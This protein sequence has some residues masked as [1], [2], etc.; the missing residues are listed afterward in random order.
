MGM[1]GKAVGIAVV[2]TAV[3]T[4][5]VGV[6]VGTTVV[7]ERVGAAVGAFV[8]QTASLEMVHGESSG[9]APQ[10]VQRPQ[11]WKPDALHV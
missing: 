1:V 2:G 8:W 4:T 11:G 9:L 10:D 7:G 3:G 6:A 5:V